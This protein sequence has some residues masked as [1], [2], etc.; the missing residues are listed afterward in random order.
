MQFLR[1]YFPKSP[2]FSGIAPRSTDPGA[3]AGNL[4][5]PIQPRLFGYFPSKTEKIKFD[6]NFCIAKWIFLRYNSQ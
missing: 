5:L 1:D 3:S 6:G 2:D 4:H